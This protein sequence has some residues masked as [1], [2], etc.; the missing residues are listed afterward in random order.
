MIM[1]MPTLNFFSKNDNTVLVTF[2]LS[3]IVFNFT[4]RSLVW[5]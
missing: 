4:L 2:D 5:Q 1:K 3:L